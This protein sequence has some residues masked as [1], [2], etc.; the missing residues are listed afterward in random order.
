MTGGPRV[1]T[2]GPLASVRLQ[3]LSRFLIAPGR[4]HWH[5]EAEA[6]LAPGRAEVNMYNT[7][8]VPLDGYHF[9]EQALG[10]ARRLAGLFGARLHQCN[11][12][13]P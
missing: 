13:G 10:T 7:I 5:D 3:D 6:T 9:A 1:Q 4:S 2:R 8:V 11:T 12:R